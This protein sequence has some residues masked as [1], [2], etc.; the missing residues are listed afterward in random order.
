MVL[1][2][3]NPFTEHASQGNKSISIMSTQTYV[4][5]YYHRTTYTASACTG[6]ESDLTTAGIVEHLERALIHVADD[7]EAD[8]RP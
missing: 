4:P 3:K 8:V 1:N 6:S 7:A 5:M 2:M